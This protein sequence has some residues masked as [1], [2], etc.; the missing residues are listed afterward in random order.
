MRLIINEKGVRTLECKE[1]ELIC[2]SC[3]KKLDN[4]IYYCDK[5]KAIY[6][7]NCNCKGF[8]HEEE[9]THWKIDQVRFEE[10]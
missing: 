5:S 1:N 4:Y 10:E 9:H 3:G 8:W 6:C 7:I 2:A